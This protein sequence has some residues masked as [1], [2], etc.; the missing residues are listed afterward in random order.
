MCYLYSFSIIKKM[1]FYQLSFINLKFLRFNFLGAIIILTIICSMFNDIN[2]FNTQISRMEVPP[3][4]N[5]PG[6]KKID[7]SRGEDFWILTNDDK[8]M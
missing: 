7:V 1:A 6:I 5:N 2:N 3:F 4:P 8:V